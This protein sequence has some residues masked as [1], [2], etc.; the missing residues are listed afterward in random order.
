MT[1][2]SLDKLIEQLRDNQVLEE[3]KLDNNNFS[4]PAVACLA[5]LLLDTLSLRIL[6]AEKCSLDEFAGESIK[7]G[8]GRNTTLEELY[9]RSNNLY[10]VGCIGICE[11]LATNTT[12]K[13][14]DIGENRLREKS[15]LAVGAMLGKN[16]TLE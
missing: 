12:L 5:S 13:I 14:L 6:S 4:G 9:L 8:I 15:G 16:R 10:D 3:L 7:N 2:T 1:T 11:S